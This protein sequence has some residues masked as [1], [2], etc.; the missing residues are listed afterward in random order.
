MVRPPRFGRA[1]AFDGR[2]QLASV[3]EALVLAILVTVLGVEIVLAGDIVVSNFGG[4]LNTQDN[5][6]TI[7]PTQAQDLLN[8]N[9]MPGGAAVYKRDGYA[10]YK[11]LPINTSTTSVHGGYH[12]QQV[13][14]NDVQ[15]WGND[16]ELSASVSA[17][18]FV[19]IAT[20]TV[21]STWQCADSQGFAY[22]LTSS[23]DMGIKT[24]GSVANT[25]FQSS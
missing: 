2:P 18:D 10:L 17:A 3:T 22:C 21:G 20:A 8:V 16:N 11:N 14:G 23:H 1:H 19:K 4:G 7:S 5:P 9:F 12:F 15:L 24:D 6:A 25:S 13:G